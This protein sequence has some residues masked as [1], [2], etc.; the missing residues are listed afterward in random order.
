MIFSVVILSIL[1]GITEFLPISSSGHLLLFPWIFNL[2]NPG[3]AFDAA[4][5]VGTALALV[6]FFWKDFYNLI[7]KRDKLLLYILIASVPAALA[8]FFGDKLIEEYLHQG[9]IAPLIVGLGIIFFGGL[10]YYID[11]NAK[12]DKDLAHIGKKR[13]LFIGLAQVLALIPGTSRSGITITAGEFLGLNRESAARFSFL[14]AT[15][16]S[17]GAGLYKLTQIIN[18]PSGGLSVWLVLLGIII[19]FIT[20]MVVIKWLLDFLKKHSLLVFVWY[21]FILG[22]LIVALWLIRR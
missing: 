19:A 4:I 1:Q 12:L 21:R 14:L 13:A 17:L 20:G 15:P 6:I 7:K 22:A 5:H 11:H 18:E 10:M 8:G 16:I 9:T 3:L 2:P